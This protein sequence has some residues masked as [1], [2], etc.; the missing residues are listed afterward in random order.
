MLGLLSMKGIVPIS[1]CSELRTTVL[2]CYLRPYV[3][4][5]VGWNI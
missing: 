2:I 5:N 4:G 1:V 3:H